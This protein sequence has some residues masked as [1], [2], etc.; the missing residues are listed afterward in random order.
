MN[1]DLAGFCVI[2]FV[3]SLF[4]AC[5]CLIRSVISKAEVQQQNQR[6]E[7]DSQN[8]LREI[9][10]FQVFPLITFFL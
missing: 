4:F 8:N 3:L 2:I 10:I 6:R 9:I 1:K 7:D 5:R